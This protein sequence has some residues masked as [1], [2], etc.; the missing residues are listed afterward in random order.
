MQG[1][2]K[3]EEPYRSLKRVSDLVSKVKAVNE[4]LL[5]E[6]RLDAVEFIDNKIKQLECEINKSAIGTAELSN[7][8]LR[9]LQLLKAEIE[10]EKS[11]S[12]I[13]MLKNQRIEILFDKSLDDLEKKI[14]E[15]ARQKEQA[16]QVED[17]EMAAT[18]TETIIEDKNRSAKPPKVVVD[19]EVAAL[20]SKISD[21][22]YLETDEAVDAFVEELR[23]ELKQLIQ[24]E[25]RVRIR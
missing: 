20:Y 4:R 5:A 14:Q 12:T 7:Q 9:P 11:L 2:A 6:K 18:A 8:L 19:V 1:I 10:K 21:S 13:Y 25:K 22:V 17:Y 24:D 3:L 16:E 15:V 23:A